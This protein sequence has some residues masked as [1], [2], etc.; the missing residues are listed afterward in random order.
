MIGYP[1]KSMKTVLLDNILSE[2]ELFFLYKEIIAARGWAVNGVSNIF[3]LNNPNAYQNLPMFH[4]LDGDNISNY[5]MY[6]YGQTLV[7]RIAK[8]LEDKKIGM[9]TNLSRMWFNM[10]PVGYKHHLHVDHSGEFQSIVMFMS[11]V[12]ESSW[13][14]SFYVDGEEFKFKPG[15]AVIFNSDEY[16]MGEEPSSAAMNWSRLSCNMIVEKKLSA[17]TNFINPGE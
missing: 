7:Y 13:R 1:L 5:P 11:P 3:G 12:W 16:H 10:T 15:S 14:G 17:N 8:I 4:V 6:F 9:H 2:K